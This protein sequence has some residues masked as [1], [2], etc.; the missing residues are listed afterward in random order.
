METI[1]ININRIPYWLTFDRIKIETDKGIEEIENKIICFYKSTPPNDINYGTQLK[2]ADNI[3]IVFESTQNAREHAINFLESIV[4]PPN[5]IHPLHY[6]KENL[7]EI[8]HKSLIFDIGLQNS[9]EITESLEGIMTNCTLASNPPYL[10]G[11]ARIE[12]NQGQTRTFN[13]FE[14]KRIRS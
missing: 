14:I 12:T 4:Y 10:P 9:D 3:G 11:T 13:F 1:Q 7:S 6:K 5:F 8:M 2:N